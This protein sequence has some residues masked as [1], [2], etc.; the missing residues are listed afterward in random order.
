[1]ASK[2]RRLNRFALFLLAVG[3]LLIGLTF[4]HVYTQQPL[5]Q[6]VFPAG[7]VE[8]VQDSQGEDKKQSE[9]DN[10][11]EALEDMRTELADAVTVLSLNG[12]APIVT[13][14]AKEAETCATALR[15]L[16]EQA[17]E[18][19]PEFLISGRLF[20][21]DELERGERVAI[22]D[23]ELALKAFR[24]TDIVGR[25]LV[26]SGETY[27]VVG[28]L[29]HDRE[30]GELEE[31]YLY[32]PL[33]TVR[34]DGIQLQTLTLSARPVENGGA[35]TMFQSQAVLLSAEGTFYDLRQEGTGA[36]MWARYLL[37]F[38]AFSFLYAALLKWIAWV[39]HFREKM[40]YKLSQSYIPKLLPYFAVQFIL[41]AIGLAALALCAAY[42]FTQLIHPVYVYPDYV[43]AVLVEP[44]EVIK[45]FWNLQTQGAAAIVYRSV[46]SIQMAFYTGVCRWGAVL[47]IWGALRVRRKNS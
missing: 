5:L 18:L 4:L 23:E 24:M 35:M 34:K 17:Y 46:Q 19:Y 20:Y 37:C 14:E 8:V 33:E 9:L 26:L 22:L 29:R 43:P 25:E 42:V 27:R 45:T 10:Q 1:M 2:T 38:A 41:R 7:Q 21:P 3:V 16:G 12:Y 28:V 6:Y 31:H 32:L 13:I 30:V 11:I 39:N 44:E 15:A 36:T 40:S 47:C